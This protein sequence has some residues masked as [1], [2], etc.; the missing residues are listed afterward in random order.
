MNGKILAQSPNLE[1][2][3]Y[4]NFTENKNEVSVDENE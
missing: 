3:H 1:L 2:F 4:L